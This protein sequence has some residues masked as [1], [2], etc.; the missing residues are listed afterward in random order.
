[1]KVGV[2]GCGWVA[3]HGHLPALAR[4]DA[5]EVVALADR[6]P[7]R[8]SH[9]AETW[10]VLR[11]HSDHLEL[12]DNPEIEAVVVC[13][14]TEFHVEVAHAAVEAGKHLL[15]E[16]PPA[17]GLDEWDRLAARLDESEITF[18]LGL[19]MR[20]HLGFAKARELIRAG[21]LGAVQSLR[22][23]ISNDSL[24]QPGRSWRRG[25]RLGGGVLMEMGVHHLDLWSHLLS[26]DVEQVFATVHG[27]DEN[28]VV[29]GRMQSGIPVTSVFSHR[30]ADLNE[31]EVYG[32]AAM[33]KASPYQ[34]PRLLD[35]DT[36]P[37]T[38]RA[39]LGEA[40]PPL[41]LPHLARNRRAGGFFV[42]SFAA[43][44]RHFADAVQRGR[45]PSPGPA[46]PG[47]CCR[48]CW[49]PRP[50]RPRTAPWPAPTPRR[51]SLRRRPA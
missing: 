15:L 46:R 17:L 31:I 44:W 42:S 26:E 38:I 8:L 29:T 48:S 2:I 3:E 9:L 41:S 50:R 32:A 34:P 6:D 36:K 5:A 12:L 4:V 28:M 49:P 18:M 51:R 47:G 25:R 21:R 14:P 35:V 30:T 24:K 1:M 11:R 27:D 7:D 22:T 43:Q 45:P 40:A 33:L 13:V 10:S 23:T 16:K 37:W 39:R 20:R 19:N